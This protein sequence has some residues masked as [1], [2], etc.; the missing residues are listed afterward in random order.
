M[1][2]R[3]AFDFDADRTAIGLGD[4]LEKTRFEP[5][6]HLGLDV[7]HL[8]QHLAL[9]RHHVGGARAEHHVADVPY[10]I[11]IGEAAE[12][13]IRH[14]TE[15]DQGGAGIA[16]HCHRGGAGVVRGPEAA[17]AKTPDPDQRRHHADALAGRFHAW[18]LLDMGF[19]VAQL[20]FAIEPMRRRLAG[21]RPQR[22]R[23][24]CAILR[25]GCRDF[26]LRD[27][28]KIRTAA[29]KGQEGALLVLE[30]DDI[31]A[32]R[33]RL[34]FFDRAARDLEG[35]ADTERAVEPA[36]LRDGVGMRTHQDRLFGM[37]GAPEHIT[38]PVH[39]GIETG[40]AQLVDEPAPCLDV[41]DGKRG[42][43]DPGLIGADARQLAQI[44]NEPVAIDSGHV[45]SL[46]RIGLMVG[47]S[48][49]SRF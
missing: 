23:E 36:A 14:G 38:D 3:R 47:G 2:A 18:P 8:Q 11:A 39:R 7:A 17:N 13:G 28:G 43:I 46:A 37:G 9:A 30:R 19:E 45:V 44:G 22:G 35:V 34:A 26:R 27:I 42:A 21:N 1:D 49:T 6:Q 40:D 12:L 33:D 32:G 20:P 31:D 41:L 25:F 15:L 10:G 16:A 4:E 5:V 48:G 29:E 24:R